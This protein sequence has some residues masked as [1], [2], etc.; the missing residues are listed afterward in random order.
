VV[1]VAGLV[2]FTIDPF[3]VLGPAL[4]TEL[5]WPDS[6]SGLFLTALGVGMVLGSIKPRSGRPWRRGVAWWVALLAVSVVAF[7][8][9]PWAWL[10]VAAAL[11]AGAASLLA[12]SSAQAFLLKK[13]KPTEY[14]RVMAVWTIA[15]AG[16]RPI[17]SISDGWLAVQIGP[18]WA[19]FIIALPA[20]IASLPFFL[21]VPGRRSFVRYI[22][23]PPVRLARRIASVPSAATGASLVEHV[24][25]VGHVGMARGSSGLGLAE[26]HHTD[27]K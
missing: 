17:A 8:V 24:G 9:S 6:W 26:A 2:T 20:L 15:F 5:G 1:A 3:T 4:A 16:S 18:R 14:G 13:V 25:H 23:R 21:S 7:V 19:G 11:V 10:A 12:L 22:W 27:G